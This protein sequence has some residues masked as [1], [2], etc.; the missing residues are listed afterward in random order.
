MQREYGDNANVPIEEASS[1]LDDF[2]GDK[3]DEILGSTATTVDE[4]P[5]LLAAALVAYGGTPG[6]REARRKARKPRAGRST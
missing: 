5:N 4:L 6:N 2:F 1:I 3:L